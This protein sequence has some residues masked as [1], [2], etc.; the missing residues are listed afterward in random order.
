MTCVS[1]VQF[2]L[3]ALLALVPASAFA[4]PFTI[5]SVTSDCGSCFGGAVDEISY[6]AASWT[7]TG[8]YTNVSI[9]ATLTANAAAYPVTAY[10]TTAIGPSETVADQIATST[11]SISGAGLEQYTFFSGLSLGPG[12][13]YLVLDSDAGFGVAFWSRVPSGIGPHTITTASGVTYNDDYE[14]DFYST[15][16]DE[17]NPPDSPFQ[18]EGDLGLNFQVTGDTVSP[19]PEPSSIGLV[20]IGMAGGLCFFGRRLAA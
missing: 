17:L 20:L 1:A 12:T 8:A 16:V 13:Y 15:G 2:A 10:L 9:A 5:V 11:V 18:A 6:Y 19:V 7:A 3:G 4:D 14:A